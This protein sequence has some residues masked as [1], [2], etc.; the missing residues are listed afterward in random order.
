MAHGV[1][2]GWQVAAMNLTTLITGLLLALPGAAV[3]SPPTLVAISGVA[4]DHHHLG[5]TVDRDGGIALLSYATSSDPATA[6]FGVLQLRRCGNGWC[7]AGEAAFAQGADATSATFACD[8]HSVLFASRRSE[9]RDGAR[10]DLD[11]W[12]VAWRKGRFGAPQ[13]LPAPS[14]SPDDDYAASES[15]DGT[16]VVASARAGGAGMLDLYRIDRGKAAPLAVN[17]RWIENGPALLAGRGLIFEGSGWTGNVGGPAGDLF[18]TCPDAAGKLRATRIDALASAASD[19]APAI[20]RDRLFFVS[21]RSGIA[22]AY[23]TSAPAC[24]HP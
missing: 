4:E 22:R 18:L 13:R 20:W 3:A 15:C 19:R 24:R 12:R 16:L 14:N 9:G 11:L 8:G 1:A 10:D 5:F 21:N 17:S 6:R 2:G 23:E 7:A